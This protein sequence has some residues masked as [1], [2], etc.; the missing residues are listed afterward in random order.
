MLGRRS[1]RNGLRVYGDGEAV[2]LDPED[3]DAV[4]LI[5]AT[6]VLVALAACGESMPAPVT[7]DVSCGDDASFW[8]TPDRDASVAELCNGDT[9]AACLH[10]IWGR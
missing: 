8:A 4:N 10:N 5:L 7:V 1:I 6:A 9:D 3:E 2:M